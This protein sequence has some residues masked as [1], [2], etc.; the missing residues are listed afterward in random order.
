MAEV[1]DLE[2]RK[3]T[4]AQ[5]YS[6]QLAYR[7][8]SLSYTRQLPKEYAQQTQM[9]QEVVNLRNIAKQTKSLF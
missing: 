7:N 1:Q 4:L 6:D 3:E 9:E 8:E 5:G 2:S